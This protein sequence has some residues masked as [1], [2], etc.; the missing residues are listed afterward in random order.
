MAAQPAYP[1][2]RHGKI[3]I[4]VSAITH[5]TSTDGGEVH[6]LTTL[7]E[8]LAVLTHAKTVEEVYEAAV[9]SL[10]AATG[11]DRAAVL[12]FDQD[13]VMRFKISCGLSSEYREAVTGH[14]PWTRG[15][16]NAQ[17]VLISD[18]LTDE[19]VRAHEPVFVREQI[20]ALAFIPLSLETG[21]V[22]KFML[23]Y[24]DPHEFAEE[25][26]ATAQVIASHVA[27]VMER[28]R[29][30]AALAHSQHRLQTILDNSSTVIFLKDVHG[31]YLLVNRR[32]EDLFHVSKTEVIGKTD[33]DI[34]P[35]AMAE[36][37]QENDRRVLAMKEPLTFE[38]KAPHDDGIHTYLS[39]KFAID[40][41]DGTTAG[42]CGIATDITDR[43][44]LEMASRHLAAIVQG[45]E[46]A[47]VSKDLNGIITSWNRGAERIFGYTAAEA[48][49][50]PVSI[51]ALPERNEMPAILNQIR[52]GKPVEHYETLR[53][54]KDGKTIHVSLTVSPIR[55]PSGRIIGASKIARDITERKEI[56]RER[57]LLLAQEQEARKTAEL[58][59]SVG[60][61]MAT[62]LEHEKLVQSV[63]D[64]ATEL[65][66]A[67]V[68]T[69]FHNALNEEGQ[70]Y[71]PYALSGVAR[72]VFAELPMPRK[73]EI[74]LPTLRGEAVRCD[75]I[76]RDPRYGKNPPNHEML[77]GHL[78]IRS[79]L[80]APIVSRS[81]EV[82]GGLFFGHSTSGKFTEQHE[83]ILTGVAAQA[84]IAMDN[85]QLF[86]QS[87]WIQNELRRSNEELRR[88][89][90]DLETFA[91][92]ASHD[93]QEPLRTVALSAQLLERR[94]GE[95]LDADAQQF[96]DAIVQG[97]D[98]MRTLIRDVLSYATATKYA[99]G[100]PQ[101]VDSASVLAA[102]L[103]NLKGLIEQS[104][105]VITSSGLPVLLVHENRLAQ[106]F[107]NLISNALK[108]RREEA[109]RVHI[110]AVERD[111][112]SMFSVVDNG[113]GVDREFANQIFGLFKRL[114]TRDKY[115]G[116]GIG[117]AICQRIVE[118]YG[119]RIWL[120]RSV[121][122][123]GSTFCFTFPTRSR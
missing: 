60:P 80:A 69:F 68:G 28:K 22:G 121:P 117:L 78:P 65:V 57:A 36:R 3:P 24:A 18:V 97:T 29:A 64:L 67:E 14:T 88:A 58:L 92:S 44:Q 62:Q 122:G 9:K 19:S 91:Y 120:E 10:L 114:H 50:N 21:V 82:L 32:F 27:L 86:E 52:Q 20:R 38:E 72:E 45:S 49:G 63:T 112:W 123:Q 70:S 54:R 103:E 1:D 110:S 116:S 115:P 105:A 11:A 23:Y 61:T 111:G 118:Q 89:N 101:S 100:P 109:P 5:S 59:N 93:L 56:E 17:A 107:Q 55:D 84:A 79:Y 98:R 90:Q 6:R 87:Q 7:N 71:A 12:A 108:Y 48:L 95:Q 37:F 76:T 35:A 106:V 16:Q 46:D 4:E 74:F 104:G 113:I 51:L 53:R 43:T 13:G 75:D 31:R 40:D 2:V 26:V 81:G 73:T 33:Y 77:E 85:A 25:E 94:S 99:E 41:L 83:A 47:I 102:V 119:G 8:L 34:F 30:E 66:G 15:T 96:L 42:V 39:I